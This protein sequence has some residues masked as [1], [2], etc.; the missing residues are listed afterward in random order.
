MTG[1]AILFADLSPKRLQLLKEVVPKASRVAVL[2]NA[3]NPANAAAWSAT[4]AAA[5]ALGVTLRSH[6]VRSANDFEGA[7][8]RIA[9]QR[10]HAIHVL[11]DALTFQFRKQIADFATEQRLSGVFD[12]REV[13]EAGG[14]VGYGPNLA[15]MLRRGGYY[16][17]KIL[18]GARPADLPM[19]QPMKFEVVIN[20]KTAKAFG[21]TIP[22][23]LLLRADQ[24][25][26]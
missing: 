21:L 18:K 12:F 1:G 24:L 26:E 19:E 6:E 9:Q 8:A 2:W 14:L 5:R 13:V 10:P 7:F 23:S 25:I 3:A 4:E 22:P 20:M 16:V 17:D 11:A 15:E